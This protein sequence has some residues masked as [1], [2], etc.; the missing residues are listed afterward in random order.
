MPLAGFVGK[1]RSKKG[2]EKAKINV[3]VFITRT[4][5]IKGGKVPKEAGELCATALVRTR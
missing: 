5:C 4:G 1:K 3:F 2:K